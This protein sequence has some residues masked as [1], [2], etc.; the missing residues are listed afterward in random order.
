MQLQQVDVSLEIL[1]KSRAA[2]H[3]VATVEVFETVD[4]PDLGPVDMAADHPLDS[5]L[6]RQV[7]HGLLELRDV[8]NR[9]LGLEFQVGGH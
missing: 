6:P 8:A 4:G 7:D 1:G 9:A 5:G 3:P 2:L